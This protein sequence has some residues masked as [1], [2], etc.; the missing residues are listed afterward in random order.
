[1]AHTLFSSPDPE[2]HK[3]LRRS[4]NSAFTSSTVA[5][6]EPLV[7]STIG[8][9]LKQIDTRFANKAGEDGVADLPSWLL[10]F[11]FDTMGQITYGSRHGFI[12]AGR[13]VKGIIGYVQSF[14]TYGFLVSIAFP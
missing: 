13:D 2:W 5:G 10:F 11:T 14:L 3:N 9:F 1:M 8:A 7:D 4:I 12:E 6:Y